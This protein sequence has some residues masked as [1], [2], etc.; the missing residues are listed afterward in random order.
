MESVGV[1]V[2]NQDLSNFTLLYVDSARHH[3]LSTSST[4]AVTAITG[5]AGALLIQY[6]IVFC[7]RLFIYFC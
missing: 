7:S 3:S 5:R 2:P 6:Q 4:L 1:R